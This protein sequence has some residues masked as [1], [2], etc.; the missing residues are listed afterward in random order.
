MLFQSAVFLFAFLPASFVLYHLARRYGRAR[1]ALIF[2]SLVFYGWWDWRLLPLLIGAIVVTWLCAA[3]AIQSE[4]KVW[5]AAGVVFNLSLLAG[6]KYANFFADA[7]APL[8]QMSAPNWNIVLPLAISFFTF[9]Q[10]SYLVDIARGERRLYGFADY[11]LYI[12]FFPHLIAGP[13][14]R[15]NEFM[16]QVNG[17]NR[18]FPEAEMLARGLV[19]LTTGLAKKLWLADPLAAISQPLFTAAANA[20]LDPVQGF[21]AALAFSLQIY[22]DFSGYTDM[23]LG[24]A[25][26]FGYRLPPN[27]DAPYRTTNLIDFWRHWHMTLSRYLRDYLYFTLGGSRFGFSRQ[28]IALLLTMVLGGLWHGAAWTFVLWGAL[29]GVGLVINHLWRRFGLPMPKA[30]GWALTFSF[31]VACFV[32][33]RASSLQQAWHVLRPIG[34]VVGMVT[35]LAALPGKTGVVL[36]VATLFALIW[37]AYPDAIDRYLEAKRV[38]A[39]GLGL[40]ATAIVV[41]ILGADGYA[42]FLYFQF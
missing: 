39:V 20:P 27:F 21:V 6:F 11:M 3:G 1:D 7:A 24:L 29:H 30:L 26:L 10:I 4:R 36:V 2:V 14:V 33:F 41:T 37:P 9:H 38:I 31:V 17:A 15:H 19:L 35:G 5:L 42:P 23:A 12:V 18:C 13:I 22:F 34:D 40:S 28:V 8:L 16:P 32:L 25:L